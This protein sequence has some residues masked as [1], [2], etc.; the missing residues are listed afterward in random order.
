MSLIQHQIIS[1]LAI[2]QK[3][4]LDTHTH[5]HTWGHTEAHMFV[6]N[7]A[8]GVAQRCWVRWTCTYSE[9]S[10]YSSQGVRLEE[11]RLGHVCRAIQEHTCLHA[12]MQRW[13][14]RRTYIHVLMHL[15]TLNFHSF[16][17]KGNCLLLI[18]L[19]NYLSTRWN[20]NFLNYLTAM[21][22]FGEILVHWTVIITSQ[23]THHVI[24]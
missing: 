17:K 13:R 4:S 18:T 20:V 10:T 3:G 21:T 22:N 11:A 16:L 23:L 19:S 12:T 8:K 9:T 2:W 15:Y 6:C 5:T 7:Y 14:V 24:A 1:V